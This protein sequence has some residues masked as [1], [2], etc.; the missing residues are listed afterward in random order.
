M[1]D[2]KDKGTRTEMLVR[3]T[4]RKLTKLQWERTP[5]SGALNA[6]HGLKADIYIPNEHNLFSVEVKG[7]KD[8]HISSKILTDKTPQ[9]EEWWIQASRQAAETNKKPLLIFKHDRG[10][11]FCATNMLV[12][13]EVPRYLY[14][15]YLD[16][17]ILR[18]EDFINF[19]KPEFIK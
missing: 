9:I 13:D 2:S 6:V 7:Y 19:C 4:L 15:N 10:K 5:L 11:L 12:T 3:D 14:I 18:L 8:D 16:I 1:V 17:S